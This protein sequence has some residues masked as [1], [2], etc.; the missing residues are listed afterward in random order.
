[1]SDTSMSCVATAPLPTTITY[2][3]GQSGNCLIS[4]S[5]TSVITGSHTACGGT[6]TE[7]WSFTDSCN[8]T[9]TTSRIITILPADT[10][11]FAAV[12]DPS[13]SCVATAP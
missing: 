10:A 3:N 7:T 11:T 12:S 5:V 1:V 9:I 6:Y 2:T 13:M 4:G 8:R